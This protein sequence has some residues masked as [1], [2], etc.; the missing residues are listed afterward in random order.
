MI[1]ILGPIQINVNVYLLTNA[2]LIEI[3]LLSLFLLCIQDLE[4]TYLEQYHFQFQGYTLL[5]S[6]CLAQPA[7]S[8]LNVGFNASATMN[9][10]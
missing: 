4:Y 1:T 3:S 8:A 2:F 5:F 9:K 7:Y 6:P 10:T